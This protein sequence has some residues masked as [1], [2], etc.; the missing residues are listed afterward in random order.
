MKLLRRKSPDPKVTWLASQPWWNNL[1]AA[2]LELLASTGDRTRVAAG[3]TLM[4]EGHLGQES[5]VIVTGE[6][7]ILHDGEVIARLGPGEVIGELALLDGIP[8]TANVRAATDVE[9]L[10]F[11]VRALRQMLAASARVAAQVRDAAASHR[12]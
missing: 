6:V 5:A 2:D 1:P 7:E 10:A 4:V 11:G 3:T 12:G 9:L 8:R